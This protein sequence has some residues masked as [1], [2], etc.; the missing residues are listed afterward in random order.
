M[1]WLVILAWIVLLG[2]AALFAQQA[3]G[4]N[5]DEA[6]RLFLALPA[7]Q[8]VTFGIAA[9]LALFLI[10][11][12]VW[13]SEVLTRRTKVFKSL[14]RSVDGLRNE[15]A[16]A[17]DVQRNFEAAGEHLNTID[18]VDV[19]TSLQTRLTESEQ[20]VAFQKS[21][22]ESVDLRERLQDIRLRQQALR[23]QIGE[24]GETRRT[25]EP[26]F[27]EL[28]ER[29]AQLEQSLADIETDDNKNSLANR[30]KQV[31]GDV[32]QIQARLKALMES[33][34]TLTRFREEFGA[35]QTQ[36]VRLQAPDEGLA[37]MID[38]LHA[39]R[40]QLAQT[41]GALETHGEERLAA[42]VEAL[43]RSKLE[44]EQRI[45]SLDDCFAI[46]DTVRRDFGELEERRAHLTQALAA[47]ETDA[48]GRKLADR[49]NELN[50]FAAQ[51]RLR[52]RVLQDSSTALNGF[53]QDIDKSQ[54]A[55]V[56]LQSSVD[57]IEAL[58][59]DLQ[60]RRDRL[61]KGLNEIELHGDDKLSARV[62]AL[63]RSK[64]ETEQRVAQIVEQFAKLDSIRSE[65]GGLFTKLNGTLDRL[66]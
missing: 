29:Q 42:R 64:V 23:K 47:V 62:E 2:A 49:Q 55:L 35:S 25:I 4:F 1:M 45:A 54:A 26:V 13:Q 27:G 56:P 22:N 20:R 39:R 24:V 41:L 28:K 32:A 21:R 57:G 52:V 33:W 34:E 19:I 38:E 10:V 50:E 59:A 12:S 17:D 14:Q 53:K 61:I 48:S 7:P 44:T 40:D 46:L 43:A 6:P 36:L 5:L 51:T 15:T 8:Q 31:S 65:I 18:P 3:F 37:A 58:I 11:F 16:R 30:L 63:Y 66:R 60:G 9:I